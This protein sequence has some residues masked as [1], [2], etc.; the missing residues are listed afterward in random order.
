MT[1]IDATPVGTRVPSPAKSNWLR[2]NW[3]LLLAVAALIV[4]IMLPTPRACP[5]P[6]SA[7]SRSWPSP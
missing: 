6:A 4:V 1:A 2:T 5:S 3:G 7:C